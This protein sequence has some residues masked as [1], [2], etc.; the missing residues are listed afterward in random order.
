MTHTFTL[1][2][3]EWIGV[4]QKLEHR[5]EQ[6]WIH[7]QEAERAARRIETMLEEQEALP[8]YERFSATWPTGTEGDIVSVDMWH[9]FGAPHDQA[10]PEKIATG[11]LAQEWDRAHL[12]RY[13][14]KLLDVT[15]G[16]TLLFLVDT[17][18]GGRH[19][20]SIRFPDES[21]PE[22]HQFGGAE[23]KA[24]LAAA[25]AHLE[26]PDKEWPYR[27]VTQQLKTKVGEQTTFRRFVAEIAVEQVDG[28][29]APIT[30]GWVA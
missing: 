18:F 5:V 1:T 10:E 27:I 2:V 23:A 11:F 29:L 12:W 8:P 9:L 20:V 6:R 17:G 30:G 21:A 3:S 15:D 25:L 28:T 19:E 26:H 14:A 24:V 7:W 13:R 16:D 4:K 22:L